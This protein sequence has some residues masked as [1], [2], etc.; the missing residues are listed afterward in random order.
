M[1][2][3]QLRQE[4]LKCRGFGS[5][6]GNGPWSGQLSPL[7][8]PPHQPAVAA[9]DL[10]QAPDGPEHPEDAVR[11]DSGEGIVEVLERFK[12]IPV[13]HLAA[14]GTLEQNRVRDVI[15]GCVRQYT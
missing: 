10:P 15:A 4:L 12:R 5:S 13:V 2:D 7:I 9:L 6:R 1:A 14:L 3:L 11:D 8:F